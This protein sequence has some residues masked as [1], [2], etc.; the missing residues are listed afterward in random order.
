MSGP[1]SAADIDAAAGR[2]SDV[3][4]RTPLEFCYRLSAATGAQVYLKREDLQSVRSYKV[5]GAYNLLK[6]LTDDELRAGVV[7][8]SAGNHAQGFALACR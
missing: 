7:C 3:V 4:L 2:I 6:Q 8:S 1:L 5:R